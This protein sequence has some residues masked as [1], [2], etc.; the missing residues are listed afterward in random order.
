MIAGDFEAMLVSRELSGTAT[1]SHTSAAATAN[2]SGILFLPAPVV[3]SRESSG[4]ITGKDIIGSFGY[5]SIAPDGFIADDVPATGPY[6]GE[7]LVT[8]AENRIVRMVAID[9][10]KL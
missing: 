6:P 10:F 9:E 5:K 8:A 1:V 7:L 4:V 3:L 2:S